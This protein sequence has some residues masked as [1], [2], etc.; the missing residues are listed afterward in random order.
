[1]KEFGTMENLLANTDK[2]SGKMK[3]NI[4]ANKEK[5]LLSKKLATILLD[6][7]VVFDEN[8]YELSTPDV[9]KTDALFN[10][11]EFRRMAEQF[12]AIFK[13]G[14]APSQLN[15]V[16]EAKLYKKPTKNEDQFDLFG[17]TQNEES[18]DETRHQYYNSLE[19]TV[20]F[21]QTIQGE[22]AVKLLLQ[23]LQ[24]QTSVCFDTET[25]GLD[26]LHA[27]LVGIS[28]SYEKG[29]GFYVPFPENQEEVQVLVNK[30]IPFFENENDFVLLTTL[31][32]HQ[33]KS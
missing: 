24:N 13:K 3:D 4:E 17:S 28:F 2:L 19:N 5:G 21:Y 33:R 8:D 26:A 22:L 25:T 6:C 18:S 31:K 9:A 10:E 12:D 27:E 15:Q 7:P 16:D 23:N 29:K 11:L 1:M 20:H 32:T 14:G 30:F